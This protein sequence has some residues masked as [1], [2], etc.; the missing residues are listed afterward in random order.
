MTPQPLTTRDKFAYGLLM[1]ICCVHVA[2]GR[3]SILGVEKPIHATV[4]HE[5]AN[6]THPLGLLWT[7]LRTGDSK[8]YWSSEGRYLDIF[9]K[10]TK[11]ESGNLRVKAADFSSVTLPAI[12]IYSKSGKLV[13]SESIK[14]T[15]KAADIT[16]IARGH[17]G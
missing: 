5:T 13:Y 7:A 6:D 16:A 8:T 11:D 2:Q 9:D 14:P 10:D 12:L 17:G 15:A 1:A 4:V 3:L